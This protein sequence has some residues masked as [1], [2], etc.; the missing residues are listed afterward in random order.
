M[1]TVQLALRA[2]GVVALS[3]VSVTV[4]SGQDSRAVSQPESTKQN[5]RATLQVRLR[6]QDETPFLGVAN[7]RLVPSVDYEILSTRS[8]VQGDYVFFG[9]EPG[10]YLLEVS[11]PGYLGTQSS[12]EVE[13][14]ER[15]ANAIRSNE[16]EVGDQ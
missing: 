4:V 14:R 2:V 13:G 7:V 15:T 8:E 5:S 3:L 12:T 9:V 6:L 11:A 10:K 16:T 1:P